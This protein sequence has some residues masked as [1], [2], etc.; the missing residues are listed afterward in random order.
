MLTGKK[1]E[2]SKASDT[3]E[4]LTRRD[5]EKLEMELVNYQRLARQSS[6]RGQHD[7]YYHDQVRRLAAVLGIGEGIRDSEVNS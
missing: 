1:N 7:T 5:R 3:A 6:E 4:K 2:S